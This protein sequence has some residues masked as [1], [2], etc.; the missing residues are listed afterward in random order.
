MNWIIIF[1][2]IVGVLSPLIKKVSDDNIELHDQ[3]LDK[4]FQV[5]VD[6]LNKAAFN[7]RGEITRIN[8]R[9]FNIY[10]TGQNQ[11][12]YFFYGFGNLTI[13]WKFKYFQKE[14]VHQ[15]IYHEVNDINAIAQQ[16]I[17][18]D[19]IKEME[20]AIDRHKNNVFDGR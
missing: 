20:R 9:K 19:M 10:E 17:G 13:T 1:I 18:E 6:V 5:I 3:L 16:R 14:M 12:I 11:I 4:K 8:K 15:K 7:M 2:I